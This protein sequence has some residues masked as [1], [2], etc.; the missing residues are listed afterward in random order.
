VRETDP[1]DD[2]GELSL[3]TPRIHGELLMLGYI[4]SRYLPAPFEH[5]NSYADRHTERTVFDCSNER[6]TGIRLIQLSNPLDA[7]RGAMKRLYAGDTRPVELAYVAVTSRLTDRPIN[8]NLVAQSAAGKNFSVDTALKFCPPE[9]YYKLSA[10]S[11][12]ALIYTEENFSHRTIII[13]E[14][15]SIPV[16]GP[17]ASAIRSIIYDGVMSYDVVEKNPA[18]NK[19]EVR[20]ITKTGPTNLITRGV[21]QLEAQMSTRMLALGISDSSE[22]TRA[23]LKAEPKV[24]MGEV[25]QTLSAAEEKEFWAFQR[26]LGCVTKGVVVPFAGH[27]AD[28]IPANAV[29][30]RRDFRQLLT[31]VQTIAILCQEHRTRTDDDLIVAHPE[32]YREARRLLA[33]LFDTIAVE[34]A[35]S[36]IRERPSKPSRRRARYR[37]PHWPSGYNLGNRPSR[38]A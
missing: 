3:G 30:M 2:P 9:T 7:V 35:T 11:P 4:V 12:R 5:S 8:L 33:T 13:G 19:L 34:G 28:L 31:C 38:G 18:T 26:W 27:L 24:V 21:R 15:D 14:S 37:L 20:R 22:Q 25:T 6:T 1:K 17:A 29:R 23:V 10:S 36:A 16:E 32:D